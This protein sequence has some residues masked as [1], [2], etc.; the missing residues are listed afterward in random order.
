MGLHGDDVFVFVVPD[1][2][3]HLGSERDGHIIKQTQHGLL[4][5]ELTCAAKTGY[6][7]AS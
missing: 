7:V 5:P 2:L 6:P 4:A 3:E 1:V